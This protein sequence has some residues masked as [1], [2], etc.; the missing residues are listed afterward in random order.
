[1]EQYTSKPIVG[2]PPVAMTPESPSKYTAPLFDF[3]WRGQD[4]RIADDLQ[5]G[6][7]DKEAIFTQYRQGLSEVDQQYCRL[8]DHWLILDHDPNAELKPSEVMN[9]FLISLWVCKPTRTFLAYRFRTQPWG[10]VV[11]L[12]DR[13]QWVNVPQDM[14]ITDVELQRAAQFLRLL[15]EAVVSSPRMKAA[16]LL[17]LQGCMAKQWQ[18]AFVCLTSAAEALLVYSDARNRLVERLALAFAVLVA[19]SPQEM[20]GLRGRFETLYKVRSKIV[21]EGA[22]RR[23]DTAQNLNDLAEFEGLLRRLLEKILTDQEIRDAIKGNNTARQ[24]LL[25]VRGGLLE[26]TATCCTSSVR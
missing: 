24:R 13:F 22:Y 26:E 17:T 9:L 8:E 4:M 23:D 12:L 15:R 18:V 1:M 2:T 11:R 16:L 19:D 5:I 25:K 20:A 6:R 7:V 14:E 10:D 3:P 21:H